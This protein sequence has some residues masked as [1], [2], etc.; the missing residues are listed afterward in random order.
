MGRSER[1]S[2]PEEI[3]RILA[4]S[5]DNCGSGPVLHVRS[6]RRYIDDSENHI[7]VIG[8]TGKGKSQCGSLPF[9]RETLSKGESGIFVDPKGECYRQTACYV[10]KDC[11]MFC[12]D[13]R[14]PFVSRT[15]WNP[16]YYPYTMYTSEDPADQ[17]IASLMISELAAGIFP[18][19][20][21]ADP[22]WAQSARG[23]IKGLVYYLMDA[24][25][26]CQIHLN[27]LA[28]MSEQSE[29]RM[30]GTPLYKTLYERMSSGTMAKRAFSTYATAP[31]DTRASIHSVADNGLEVFARSKGLMSMLS[32]DTLF[33]ELDLDRPFAIY[34][35]LPDET[36][37]YHGLAG[38]LVSQLTRHLIRH[39]QDN[40]G[41]LFRRVNIILEELGSIGKSIP[42]LPSLM[43]A[44]RSRNLRMMLILQDASQ[45]EDIYGKTKSEAINSC[46]GITVGFSTNSWQTLTEWSERCGERTCGWKENTRE[47]LITP[48]QLAAMPVGTALILLDGR[49][50]FISHLPLYNEMYDN[51]GWKA[52]D[53]PKR[54]TKTDMP[55]FDL[56]ECLEEQKR[57]ES[58][59]QSAVEEGWFP[60][61][62]LRPA[63][64][65]KVFT[66]P[67]QT[68]PQ[69][70]VL[71]VAGETGT[72]SRTAL[73]ALKDPAKPVFTCRSQVQA[74]R[75]RRTLENMGVLCDI[76]EE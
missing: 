27:S 33:T 65:W 58:R 59:M 48:V 4:D 13:F 17:D 14:N 70:A 15:C 74:V 68:F 23:Y 32:V 34:I 53:T 76:R 66:H 42:D 51:T 36:D 38:V 29:E 39:A 71:Y 57:R 47:P 61:N 8:K 2:T 22:F 69:E 10:P 31:N 63:S 56:K 12:V 30:N 41:A 3:T 19:E 43:T 28:R 20:V 16:L 62:D 52:P 26:N 67:G 54:R 24:A 44:G 5:A 60:W 50:K 9:I 46:V 18:E 45:L 6:G 37:I 55:V 64:V 72:D 11:Q 40:G 21:H 49:Y 35:I 1:W 73:K 25:E 75:H 7:A